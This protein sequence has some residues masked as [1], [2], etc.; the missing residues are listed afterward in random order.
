MHGNI[1]KQILKSHLGYGARM[2]QGDEALDWEEVKEVLWR[3]VVEEAGSCDGDSDDS[4][5]DLQ[6]WHCASDLFS[7]QCIERVPE[8]GQAPLMTTWPELRKAQ[9][10]VVGAFYEVEEREREMFSMMFYANSFSK[11]DDKIL[12]S[13][14]AH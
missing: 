11:F 14:N 10:P 6:V 12:S 7:T 1:S 13:R 2:P 8:L 3:R 4:G 9:L 5:Q